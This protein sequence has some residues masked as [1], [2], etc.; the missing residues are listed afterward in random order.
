MHGR[1]QYRKHN[2][3]LLIIFGV[4][5]LFV[6]NSFDKVKVIFFAFS[7]LIYAFIIAYIIDPIVTFIVAK[8][9]IPRWASVIIVFTLIILLIFLSVQFIIPNIV[10]SAKTLISSIPSVESINDSLNKIFDIVLNDSDNPVIQELNKLIE[11]II[12]KLG[13]ISTKFFEGF[14]NRILGFT[15][16][17]FTVIISIV[18]SIYM[19]TD[20]ED[21]IARMKR[22]LFAFT[23]S[24]NASKILSVC[25]I[26]NNTFKSFFI[27]K[28]LDSTIIGILA[29]AV[30]TLFS[31]PFASIIS[32]LIG[33]T[34]MIPY[35]GPFIGGIPSVILVL[36]FSPIKAIELAII[37]LALQQFDGLVLGPKI[38]GSQV[39]VRAFWIIGSV[40]I[41]GNLFGVW[42]MLLG[43]PIVVLFKQV[44]ESLV[45]KNLEKKGMSHFL[46][47]E[48]K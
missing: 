18:T 38:L 14:L 33:I 13:V 27:G 7:P 6:F 46:E 2:I 31:I 16:G 35:F 25:R 9:K 3:Y 19:L 15:S 34:N 41:G 24:H 47:D 36:L 44:I 4:L 12:S 17:I 32:L 42:G 11:D 29:L 8:T 10:S 23:S 21:L 43:V 30:L 45:D 37:I 22:A 26:A 1:Q 20:K 28:L 5:L 39:G 40:T 48:L